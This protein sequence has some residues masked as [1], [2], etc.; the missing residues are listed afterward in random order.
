MQINRVCPPLSYLFFADDLLLF[1]NANRKCVDTINSV[2]VE[3]CKVSGQAVSQEK[4]SIFFFKKVKEQ[5][6]N[7]L[8]ATISIPHTSDLGKYLGVPILHNRITKR[9]YQY[10]VDRVFAKLNS[11]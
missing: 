10:L 1:S 5:E 2:L 7:I 11:W 9:T 8:S 3:F 6:A 4:S